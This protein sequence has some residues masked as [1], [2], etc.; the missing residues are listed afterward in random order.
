MAASLPAVLSSSS[1]ADALLNGKMS[2]YP[3]T[4]SGS[5]GVTA[6]PLSRELRGADRPRT[7]VTP[8]P[9][10]G[11][12]PSLPPLS[13]P[14]ALPDP[15]AWALGPGRAKF[16]PALLARA[17]CRGACGAPDG[18]AAGDCGRCIANR[19]AKSEMRPCF[20]WLSASHSM[21][22]AGDVFT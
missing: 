13:I 17:A 12:W 8:P 16:A 6:S 22:S 5:G 21:D 2:W 4:D 18:L 15:A 14:A 7:A 20:T 11:R 1:A 9:A 3:P 10:T 19:S